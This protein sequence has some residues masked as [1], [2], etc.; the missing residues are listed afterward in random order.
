MIGLLFSLHSDYHVHV[1]RNIDTTDNINICE[2]MFQS[3]CGLPIC[4]PISLCTL[5]DFI[6]HNLIP[7]I[8]AIQSHLVFC[9]IL[10]FC[11]YCVFVYMCFL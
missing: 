4:F 8:N 1:Y 11:L 5:W 3:S 7:K 9:F 10:V 2:K 6:V